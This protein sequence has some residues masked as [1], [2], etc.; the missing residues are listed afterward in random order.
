MYVKYIVKLGKLYIVFYNIGFKVNKEGIYL[1]ISMCVL[2]MGIGGGDIKLYL[3]L[4]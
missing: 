4:L 3:L 1:L 2:W